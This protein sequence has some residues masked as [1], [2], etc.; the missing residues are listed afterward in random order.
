[1]FFVSIL[2]MN[3]IDVVYF[4]EKGAAKSQPLKDAIGKS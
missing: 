1:M 3:F 2:L 4:S